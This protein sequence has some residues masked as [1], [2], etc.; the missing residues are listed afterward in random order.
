MTD[1][2]V[3][4][5]LDTSGELRNFVPEIEL[6]FCYLGLGMAGC[7]IFICATEEP[8]A[9]G[10]SSSFMSQQSPATSKFA[11]QPR[12]VPN[13]ERKKAHQQLPDGNG[14]LFARAIHFA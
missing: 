2:P 4:V 13:A 1:D 3:W 12:F 11:R 14:Q 8:K 5:C 10:T 9:R 6:R 7:P